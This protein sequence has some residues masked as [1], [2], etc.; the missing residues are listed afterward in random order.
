MYT[1]Y[2]NDMPFCHAMQEVLILINAFASLL[3]M[4]SDH[5]K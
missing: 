2:L 1:Y 5:K 3:F 4:S